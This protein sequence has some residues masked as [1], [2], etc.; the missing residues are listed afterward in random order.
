MFTAGLGP[1]ATTLVSAASLAIAVPTA[2]QVFAWLATSGPRPARDATPPSLFVL[3]FLFIFVLG[4]LTGVMVAVLPFDC[5]GARHLLRRRPPA[6]R[7][8]RRPGVPDVRGALPLDAA[9]QRPRAFSERV[10]RWVF[11]LMFG[12]FNLAF[13]PMHIAGLEGMPRRVY[14]YA[15]RPR[16]EP[17][18][19][20]CRRSAPACSRPASLLFF[21]DALRVLAPATERDARRTRGAPARSS[22]CRP[23]DYGVRSIPQVDS[24]EPLW[25][26]PALPPRWPAGAHWLPGTVL[27]RPRDA[28]HHIRAA[29][30]RCTCSC[31]TGDSWWPFA[32]R[33][34][35]AGFF[36]LLTV[37]W[38][39]PAFAFGLA[40][41][42]SRRCV[43]LW[44]TDR[45]PPAPTGR[46]G[47]RRRICRSA[48]PAGARMRGG[49]R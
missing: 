42:R 49:R 17:A 28:G 2:L 22:G 10:G 19:T 1:F 47:D 25:S 27:R 12:G 16:L 13:F 41:A 40:R 38:M 34:G 18:G 33:L 46:G 4:G 15:G 35:T 43:W 45:P 36:L 8:D 48:R 11:G 21:V 29:R 3:G 23:S 32:R 30:G 20:C 44:Q 14:T 6:L 26:R 24:R 7:A 9:A 39:V 37:K 31:C 5:A